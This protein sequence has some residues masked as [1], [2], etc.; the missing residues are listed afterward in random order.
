[1]KNHICQEGVIYI[2]LLS[3]VTIKFKMNPWEVRKIFPEVTHL[4][5]LYMFPL[6]NDSKGYSI[7]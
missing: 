4:I 5:I 3:Q 2:Y 1:M 6:N 7:L